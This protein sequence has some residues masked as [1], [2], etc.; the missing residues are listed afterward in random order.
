V[1]GDC[2]DGGGGFEC[3]PGDVLC[4]AAGIFACTEEGWIETPCE[5]G[6][7]CFEGAC[8]DCVRDR[9][10]GDAEQVCAD[11][12]CVP[13]PLLALAAELRAGQV[14]APYTAQL[15]ARFGVAPYAWRVSGGAVPGGL[16]LAADGNLAGTP[17]AAGDFT[18]EATVADAA[19]AESAAQ[20]SLTVLA[21]GG[22]AI[23]TARLPVGEEGSDYVARFEAVGGRIPYGWFLVSGALPAGLRL[24]ATGIIGGQ[25]SAVGDFPIT[26][27]AVDAN[28]PPAFTQREFTLQVAI[29]PLRIVADQ[30]LDLFVTKVVTLSNVTIIGGNA[31]PYRAELQAAGGLRPYH[32]ADLPLPENLRG[33]IPQSGLPDGLTL[34]DAGVLEGTPTD[35]SQVA[36][37]AIPFTDIVLRG[38]FFFGEVRDAQAVPQVQ[39]AIFVVPVVAL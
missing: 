17:A 5:D 37:L 6:S 33:F 38:Y 24:D 39:Q 11:G 8:V 16:N 34:S 21:D 3:P 15:E 9:D 12:Q 30:L 35:P 1:N 10:C 32:W 2:V 7:A 20:F 27:R 4:G 13:A 25:P 31:L 22:L 14:G 36:E 23:T 29:A 26:V 18:F 28:T 19:G